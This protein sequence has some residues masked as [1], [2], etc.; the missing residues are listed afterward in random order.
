VETTRPVAVGVGQTG[1]CVMQCD[2]GLFV[3][4]AC[5][6]LALRKHEKVLLVSRVGS[7]SSL[8]HIGETDI[9]CLLYS[10]S[11]IILLAKRQEYER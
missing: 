9:H 10:K 11:R 6:L 7:P 3:H 8:P 2:A 4:A 1:S 5:V